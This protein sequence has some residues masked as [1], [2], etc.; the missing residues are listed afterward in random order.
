MAL[1]DIALE[2][3]TDAFRNTIEKLTVNLGIAMLNAK[4]AA[5]KQKAID[6]FKN[7]V[8]HNKEVLETAAREVSLLL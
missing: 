1:K 5:A 4:T 3:C 6:Q 8:T 7:G 2:G